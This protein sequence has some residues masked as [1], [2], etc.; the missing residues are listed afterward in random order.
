M[1]TKENLMK[2]V[3]SVLLVAAAIVA[4]GSA[5]T[6]RP[7]AIEQVSSGSCQNALMRYQLF[8][9]EHIIAGSGDG[10]PTVKDILRI[11]TLT[12]ETSEWVDGS[13]NG[14]IVSFWRPIDSRPN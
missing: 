2:Y 10:I 4:I 1:K 11:D 3:V 14:Q 7:R 12:G 6:N 13:R 8:A 9:G 5:Q